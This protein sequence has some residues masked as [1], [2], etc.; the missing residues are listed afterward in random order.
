MPHHPAT[1]ASE[2]RV[3]DVERDLTLQNRAKNPE[4]T[5]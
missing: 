5:L 1:R 2:N 4:D 3:D